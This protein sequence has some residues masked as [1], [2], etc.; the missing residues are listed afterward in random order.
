MFE[1]AENFSDTKVRDVLSVILPNGAIL[2]FVNL[3]QINALVSITAGLV[4]IGYA[5]WRWRK[6][7][8]K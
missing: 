2:S 6:D 3:T 5:V 1:R 4:T 8:K 7:V